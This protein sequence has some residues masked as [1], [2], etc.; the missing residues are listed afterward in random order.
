MRFELCVEYWLGRCFVGVMGTVW[1]AWAAGG[2]TG[3]L[4]R[5][6]GSVTLTAVS[7][8]LHHKLPRVVHHHIFSDIRH[9]TQY[10]CTHI[11]TLLHK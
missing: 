9:V 8:P 2:I 10:L 5:A 4:E 1:T 3:V 6:V 7:A 11:H